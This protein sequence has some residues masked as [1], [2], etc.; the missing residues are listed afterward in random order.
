LILLQRI[1]S[2]VKRR[3]KALDT[4]PFPLLVTIITRINVLWLARIN[5]VSQPI[6]ARSNESAKCQIW[7]TAVIG[8][9]DF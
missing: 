5:M 9:L 3:R 4:E 6:Q 8:A 7:I 1:K 2:L